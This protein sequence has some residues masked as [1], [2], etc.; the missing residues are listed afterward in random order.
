MAGASERSR[1]YCARA[2]SK[3]RLHTAPWLFGEINEF[4]AIADHAARRPGRMGARPTCFAM[5]DALR[6]G[7]DTISPGNELLDSFVPKDR[8]DPA[9]SACSAT[10]LDPGYA[11]F[12]TNWLTRRD[13][14][15]DLGKHTY[16]W[17]L[18]SRPAL[19]ARDL[20]RAAH[21]GALLACRRT[22]LSDL[23]R[24]PGWARTPLAQ[25]R[26]QRARAPAQ[27]DPVHFG[28]DRRKADPAGP[29]AGPGAAAERRQRPAPDQSTTLGPGQE[30]AP[31]DGAA[32]G[33]G[34]IAEAPNAQAKGLTNAG[35]PGVPG[36]REARPRTGE[37]V[38]RRSKPRSWGESLR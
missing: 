34:P 19:T 5:S 20:R 11:T 2:Q 32:E 29:P 27:V 14:R 24:P 6:Q 25:R 22:A 21:E 30:S 37:A 1:Y 36:W 15:S 17:P 10:N 31:R 23:P 13:G 28:Q 35:Q 3:L 33:A 9:R 16:K 8:F 18:T 7:L 26:T 4:P 12:M 38:H